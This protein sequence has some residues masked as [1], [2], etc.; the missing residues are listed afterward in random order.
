[1]TH[2]VWASILLSLLFFYLRAQPNQALFIPDTLLGP[3]LPL[4]MGQAQLQLKAGAPTATL[5]YN[6][7]A[8]MGPTLIL[9]RG[10]SV[11]ATV[12][13]TLS[14]STSL[15]WH[16]IHLPA[17]ADGGP[18]S[19]ILPLQQWNPH[20]T[21]TDRASTYWYHPHFHQKT[22]RQT[23]KG[24]FGFILVRD[25]EE[26]NLNLPRR[27]GIDDFP[28][29]LQ[30]LELDEQNQIK[31]EG[32]QD[33]IVLANG[34]LGAYL[35]VPA[36]VVRFRLLNGSNARN[37]YLGFEEAL[38]MFQIGS[39][40][41]L[42]PQPIAGNRIRLAPGERAEILV[43]FNGMAGQNFFLKSFG[44]EIPSGVQGGPTIP[45]PIGEPSMY[46]PLNG[47]DFS[48]LELRVQA[49]TPNA[50]VTI[51]NSLV[52]N[53]RI[54]EQEATEQR[55]ITFSSLVPGSP[56]GPFL[57]NDS[58][59]RL[60]RVDFQIPANQV[61]IW[62]IHNQT[63]VAHPLH[64]HGLQ[65]F[66]LDRFGVTPG[67]EEQGRKDVVLVYP[68]EQMRIIAR[69]PPF[70]DTSMPYMFHCHILTHEDEGMMGQFVVVAPTAQKPA[71]SAKIKLFP[72][73]FTDRICLEGYISQMPVKATSS[74]GR[75]MP[76]KFHESG[77]LDTESWPAGI[78]Y[79]QMGNHT[80]KVLKAGSR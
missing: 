4:S 58:L 3:I 73:P 75:V 45:V 9:R 61:E 74:I 72:N 10:W 41:G 13:N 71:Q 43:N 36:Q 18:H 24:A 68:N 1:M 46:S 26:A 12:Q 16:G 14:D 17:H 55:Q 44:S 19:P 5:S 29:A 76:L 28:I 38:P 53:T 35:S 62:N 70:A 49:P 79:L 31:P 47:I 57:I 39:D 66:I 6:Q 48:V 21:C 69:F 2:R 54:A 59:F 22:A 32:L 64:L 50:I 40:G 30:S 11:S 56:S 25:A 51:P 33:S 37:F 8:Y 77:E 7:Q 60:D 27:Y 78:Y 42:L 34:T 15:H 65:F 80:A 23:L 20:F 63:T 52:Q 67:P